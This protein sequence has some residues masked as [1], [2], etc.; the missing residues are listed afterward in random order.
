MVEDNW[1]EIR[2]GSYGVKF[3]KSLITAGWYRE[4]DE[5]EIKIAEDPS[6]P[7]FAAISIFPSTL[8][9]ESRTNKNLMKAHFEDELTKYHRLRSDLIK[10]FIAPIEE[11]IGENRWCVIDG[12]DR[13]GM[14]VGSR[15]WLHGMSDTILLQ[16]IVVYEDLGKRAIIEDLVKSAKKI[17]LGHPLSDML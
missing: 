14:A 10:K 13:K 5:D 4:E 15:L 9:A 7:Y 16:A 2:A 8:I 6:A 3:D 17:D 11:H 1:I 12:M